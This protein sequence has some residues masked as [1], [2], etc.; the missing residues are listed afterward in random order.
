MIPTAY[1]K[2][3]PDSRVWIYQSSRTFSEVECRE[4]EDRLRDFLE[5]WVSHGA[6]LPAWAGVLHRRFIVL[7]V[8]QREAGPSGCSI[9][10]SVRFLKGLEARFGVALFDRMQFAWLEGE[11]VRTAPQEAFAEKFAQGELKPETP[12]FD[13]LVETK[14]ELDRAWLKPLK[15]SWHRRFVEVR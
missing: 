8:D 1:D 6:H 7:M 13:N 12:V 4:L 10:A 15:E 2:M 11:E 9:D 5:Q 14:A 3:P